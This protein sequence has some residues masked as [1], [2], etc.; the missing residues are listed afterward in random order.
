DLVKGLAKAAGLTAEN[1]GAHSLRSGFIT[2]A[3]TDDKASLAEV[4]DVTHH[5]DIN[6]LADYRRYVNRRK[7][8]ATQRLFARPRPSPA[9]PDPAPSP[10]ELLRRRRGG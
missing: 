9:D 6:V 8:N 3:L 7:T 5:V 10:Q 4:Q 2:E 1:F